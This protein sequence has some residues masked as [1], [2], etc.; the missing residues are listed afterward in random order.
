MA[1]CI[2]YIGYSR[3]EPSIDLQFYLMAAFIGSLLWIIT[4]PAGVL[5][6]LGRKCSKKI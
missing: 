2:F 3:P 6:W 4:V 1:S 5:Y